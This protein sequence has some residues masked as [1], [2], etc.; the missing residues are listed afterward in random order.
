LTALLLVE[1]SLSRRSIQPLLQPLS[2]IPDSTSGLV[3]KLS[4]MLGP[5]SVWS[6]DSSVAGDAYAKRSL[7]KDNKLV[8]EVEPTV[9]GIVLGVGGCESVKD[10]SQ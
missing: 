5:S 2:P 1:I 10:S 7:A 8:S 4:F 9:E 3:H 6:V